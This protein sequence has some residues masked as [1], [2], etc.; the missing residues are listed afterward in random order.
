MINFSGHAGISPAGSDLP[1]EPG[2]KELALKIIHMMM[3]AEMRANLLAKN[4]EAEEEDEM[5]W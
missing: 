5:A 2:D 4:P 3:V 1:V